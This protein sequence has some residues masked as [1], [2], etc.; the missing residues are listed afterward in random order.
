MWQQLLEQIRKGETKALARAISFV[1]NEQ[2][3]YE[4]LMSALQTNKNIPVIGIT[5][6]PGAGKSTLV[7]GLVGEALKKKKRT[8]VICVDPSSPFH[9]GAL[10]GDRIRMGN[11]Y[12]NP[13]VFIRSLAT[14]GSLGGLHPKILEV[15]DLVKAAGYDLVIIETVGVGQSEVEIAG[16]ADMTVVVMVPEGGDEVQTM[17]AGLMEIADIFVVNKSDRPDADLFVKNLRQMLAPAFSTRKQEVPVMKTVASEQK[18]LPELFEAIEN[19]HGQIN[20][21]ERKFALQFK[22]AWYL[23]QKEKMKSVNRNELHA[24]LQH[25]ANQKGFNLYRFVQDYLKQYSSR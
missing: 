23:I 4:Q 25:E 13:D 8:A 1:E 20:D 19:L 17:K 10:L 9:L 14:R 24:S 6:P 12:A 15:T 22:K 5:G 7:D 21:E 16:L 2:P 11:W 18:G 3:G